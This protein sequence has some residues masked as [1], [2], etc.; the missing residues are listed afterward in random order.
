MDCIQVLC[1]Y[2]KGYLSKEQFQDIFYDAADDFENALHKNIYL[3]LL[4]T[5]FD[6]KAERIALEIALRDYILQHYSAVYDSI[7]DAYIERLIDSKEENAVLQ[8]LRKRYEKRAEVSIDCDTISRGSELID[9]IKKALGYPAFCGDNWDV[10]HDL[11]F[12][13]IFPE[14]LIFYHWDSMEERL[15]EDTAILKS[16][17]TQVGKECSVLVYA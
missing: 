6:K 2:L 1:F 8:I 14:K 13:I 15:P 5:N 3:K 9:S 10:I 4:C 7:H 16:I 11:I 12:D 17:L